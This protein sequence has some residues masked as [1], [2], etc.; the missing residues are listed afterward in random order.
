M[1][2]LQDAESDSWSV[3]AAAGRRL[4]A[5]A[6]ADDA[7]RALHLLLLDG[8]DTAVTWATAEALLQRGDVLGL[9]LVL[10]ALAVAANPNV[11]NWDASTMDEIYA[12][13]TGDPQ[14]MSD[15]GA[16][17]RGAQLRELSSDADTS[18]A[19]EARRLLDEMRKPLHQQR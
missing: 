15:D 10:K 13:I 16:L 2:A 1:T 14:W 3:R 18:V 12:A 5:H 8:Q 9:R 6:A 19:E 7:A 4:A 17:R 11:P